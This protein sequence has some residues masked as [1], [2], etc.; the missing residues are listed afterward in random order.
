MT[1][2]YTPSVADVSGGV[3]WDEDG[4]TEYGEMVY[5]E[6]DCWALAWHAA[7]LL[8]DADLQGPLLHT[9][10]RKDSWCH[11]VV[12]L[13]EDEYLDANGVHTKHEI[14]SQWGQRVY[15]VPTTLTTKV[16]AYQAYLD[17]DFNY[18]PGH[19]EANRVAICLLDEHCPQL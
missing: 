11:V 6:G 18:E 16:G 2:L 13:A 1:M 5:T 10:G 12:K 15:A 14:E 7:Q 8:E 4:L 3:L 19:A 17:V 9:V